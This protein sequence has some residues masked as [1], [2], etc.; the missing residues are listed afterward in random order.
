[1]NHTSAADKS[2]YVTMTS[3]KL[4]IQWLDKMFKLRKE[5]KYLPTTTSN[6]NTITA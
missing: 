5:Y 2:T 4:V 1:M 3:L 6:L